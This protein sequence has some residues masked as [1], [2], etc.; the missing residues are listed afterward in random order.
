VIFDWKSGFGR[1]TTRQAVELET[2][3][4]EPSSLPSR[5]AEL[6]SPRAGPEGNARNDRDRVA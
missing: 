4:R 5:H 3:V 6:T 1:L 2:K